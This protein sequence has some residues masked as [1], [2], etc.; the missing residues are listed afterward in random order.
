MAEPGDT[1]G[2]CGDMTLLTVSAP[3]VLHLLQSRTKF[4]RERDIFDL[5]IL[6]RSKPLFEQFETVE[7][8]S[9]FRRLLVA[10]RRDMLVCTCPE[11]FIRGD[12][13]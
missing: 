13:I 7:A 12:A 2:G 11:S 1:S 6:T 3:D 5:S 9:L 8:I 4:L 10:N